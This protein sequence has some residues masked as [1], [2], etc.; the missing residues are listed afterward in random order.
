MNF[1]QLLN[2]TFKKK[3]EYVQSVYFQIK[4]ASNNRNNKTQTELLTQYTRHLM[5][6]R[7]MVERATTWIPTEEI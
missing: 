2:W 3:S 6:T 1:R 5:T 7:S 4:N